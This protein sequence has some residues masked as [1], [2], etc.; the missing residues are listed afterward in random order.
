M[1]NVYRG[2][3]WECKKRNGWIEMN[4]TDMFET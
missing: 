3:Y 2:G 1:M 4:L